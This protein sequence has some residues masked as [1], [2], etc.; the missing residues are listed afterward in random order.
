MKELETLIIN[1]VDYLNDICSDQ[2][3]LKDKINFDII[4]QKIEKIKFI[5]VD[6]KSTQDLLNYLNKI[7]VEK[8]EN[9]FQFVN[10]IFKI[11][12]NDIQITIKSLEI[13]YHYITNQKVFEVCINNMEIDEYEIDVNESFG[14]SQY[15]EVKMALLRYI[16]KKSIFE[17]I[18]K[19]TLVIFIHFFQKIH[20]EKK[21]NDVDDFF[22]SFQS[23]ECKEK[24][25]NINSYPTCGYINN[26]NLYF[27]HHNKFVK[28]VESGYG[29][30]F[31][32]K[33]CKN[34]LDKEFILF[35]INGCHVISDNINYDFK[36][37][38]NTSNIK[39]YIGE[40]KCILKDCS[41]YS[42]NVN[43]IFVDVDDNKQESDA[44]P[45]EV[46]K[47]YSNFD[48][49]V[50]ELKSKINKELQENYLDSLE[51]YNK[52]SLIK[53]YSPVKKYYEV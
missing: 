27:E 41:P 22:I 39:K 16:N 51:K 34:I 45:N 15:H 2:Y 6:N 52:I 21:Y 31:F 53:E 50:S 4:A 35:R 49:V 40:G 36:S 10:E 17:D 37:E 24:E 38:I 19:K 26:G 12:S 11:Y 48:E 1:Y 43:Q 47:V 25:K 33:G 13:L 23:N 3:S 30:G 7:N 9:I 42:V 28:E 46:K 20:E 14:G 44:Y 18:I 29:K 8:T 32:C 5:D